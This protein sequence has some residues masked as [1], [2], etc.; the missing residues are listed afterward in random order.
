[1][2]YYHFT[3]VANNEVIGQ[4]ATIR[5]KDYNFDSN[6][7]ALN[8]Y[9]LKHLSNDITFCA[10]R[11]EGETLCA[12]FSF[13]ETKD[14][15][16]AVYNQI[17][18]MLTDPFHI[19]PAKQE[20]YEITMHDYM[21]DYLEGRRRD[22]AVTG[23]GRFVDISR[24]WIYDYYRN[25]TDKDPVCFDF[26]EKIIPAE[27]LAK[28]GIYDKSLRREIENIRKNVN[29]SDFHGNLVH[30]VLSARSIEAAMD[31]TGHLMQALFEAKR[32]RGRRLEVV[33]GLKCDHIMLQ[34]DYLE[35]IVEYNRGG[36]VIFDLTESFGSKPEQYVMVCETLEE[37][38]KKYRND[39]L[40]V[41]TYNM[42]Q[43]GFSHLMLPRLNKYVIPL[44]MKEGS[45]NRKAAVSYM[46]SLIASSEYAEYAD[47]AKEYMQRYPGDVFSQTDVL[48]A[49]DRFGPWCLN[50]NI[51]KAYDQEVSDTFMLEHDENEASAMEKLESL[52]GLGI[53]KDQVKML[54][55]SATVE[56]ERKKY[57][58]AEYQELCLHMIFAGNPG[59]AKTTVARLL[60]GVTKEKGLTKSGIFVAKSALDLDGMFCVPL[61]RDA[62]VAAKGGVLFI[63][64]AYSMKSE[65]AITTLIQEMENHRDEVIVILAGYTQRMKDFLDLNEG[66]KS[67]IPNW[68]DFPDYSTDE[69]VEIFQL[70]MKERGFTATDEALK[71][72]RYALDKARLVED[73]GNGRYVRNMIEYA[74]KKQSV[75]L[76]ADGTEAGTIGRE[77]LF[78][79]E[80]ADISVPE[81][82]G[83]H[84]E[85][86]KKGTAQKELDE[87][88]GLCEVKNVIRKAIAK[89]KVNKICMDKGIRKER[90]SLHMAFTGNP[91]TAKTT[92]ARKLAEIL[93]D[94]EVLPTGAFAELGRADLVSDHVGGTAKMIVKRF[95]EAQGGVLFIDEAYSLCDYHEGSFGDEAI[96]TIVQQM[97]NHRDDVIVIFAGYPEPMKK[98]VERNPGM[99]SRIAFQVHFDD[100]SL[101][102]LCQ[103]TTLMATEKGI[104]LS[105]EAMEKLRGIYKKAMQK[106][107]YGNG[108]FV[109]KILEEA[110]MNMSQRL[111]A[112]DLD[113]ESITEQLVTTVE[114]C[115]ISEP[116]EDK[117]DV[118][119]RFGFA[120]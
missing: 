1:M 31:M 56:K 86:R 41:F 88:V 77:K 19:S 100:Y 120:V 36:A 7:G 43:P 60:A 115:D 10:Y 69:L 50:K 8:A 30:Y 95:K 113:D 25:R 97:E 26:Q 119:S 91:G 68:I 33:T 39:C 52:I 108:R 15:Y 5:L 18:E 75:R 55:D 3:I 6:I 117:K 72:A 51:L 16:E 73:F 32:L 12:G 104:V 47:Q 63:D 81:M 83:H 109:R 90:A 112:L 34:R 17:V 2:R 38:L 48:A 62:F 67:R 80:E 59:T 37:L 92:V 13:D 45:G 66:L 42:N 71:A 82:D 89:F 57:L 118:T 20:P 101:E 44:S 24:M 93:K 4:N 21:D 85:E 111:I 58:G 11:E 70:M 35:K 78:L 74:M 102:E 40:F 105:D 65:A 27:P 53:V 98:F 9:M 106:E 94:E 76:L 96:T 103:I 79:F 28:T 14:T 116:K 29:H 84:T 49:F 46:K 99:T 61:I 107:D 114:A 110:E 23:Y 87:M 64:E 22:Y 54:I